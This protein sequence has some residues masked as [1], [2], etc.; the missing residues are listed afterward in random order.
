MHVVILPDRD[1][2][3]EW[4]GPKLD[5]T[6]VTLTFDLSSWKWG[7]THRPLMCCMYATYEMIQSN[8]RDKATERTGPKLGTTHVT[9]TVDLSS[10]KWGTTHRPLMCN[11]Y[12]TYEVIRSIKEEAPERT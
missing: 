6:R 12:A 2:A 10:S 1:E 8:D 7:A 3:T 9:L 11:T 5:T 4:T